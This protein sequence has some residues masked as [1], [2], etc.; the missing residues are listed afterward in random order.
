MKQKLEDEMETEVTKISQDGIALVSPKRV[1][2][3]HD[4]RVWPLRRPYASG[5]TVGVHGPLSPCDGASLSVIRVSSENHEAKIPEH[6][7]SEGSRS[8]TN[9]RKVI[10]IPPHSQALLTAQAEG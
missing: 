1:C 3:P 10:F 2:Q 7:V 6:T 5:A 4:L 8:F 9:K